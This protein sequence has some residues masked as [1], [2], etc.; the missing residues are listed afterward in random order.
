[1]PPFLFVTGGAFRGEAEAFCKTLGDRLLTK[2]FGS[3]ELERTIGRLIAEHAAV[4][5]S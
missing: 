4:R 5:T 1:M 3:G 2:P